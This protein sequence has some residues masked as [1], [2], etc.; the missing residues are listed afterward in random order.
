MRWSSA[1]ASGASAN[2]EIACVRDSPTTLL[3]C[4]QFEYH[5]LARAGDTL[6]THGSVIPWSIMFKSASRFEALSLLAANRE[7]TCSRFM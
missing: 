2:D 7:T 6:E 1:P 3:V 5:S 4:R